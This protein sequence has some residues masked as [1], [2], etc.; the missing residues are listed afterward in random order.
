MPRANTKRERVGLL[1]L[2]KRERKEE[3]V[4]LWVQPVAL[5]GASCVRFVHPLVLEVAYS[6]CNYV[7]DF[8]K[9][10]KHVLVDNYDFSSFFNVT[11][12]VLMILQSSLHHDIT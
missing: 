7:L 10:E 1:S 12:M 11:C 4:T 5:L 6:N 8:Y 2:C 9:M 3:Y